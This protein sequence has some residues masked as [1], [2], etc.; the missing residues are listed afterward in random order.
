MDYTG[1]RYLPWIENAQAGY[2]HLHRYAFVLPFVR[3]KRVLDLATG[4]GYGAAMLAGE[5]AHVTGVDIAREAIA[6]ASSRYQR[7]NLTFVQG[8]M[9]DVPEI[10]GNEFDV[11]VCFESI[12]HVLDQAEVLSEAKRLLREGGLFFISTPNKLL[13]GDAA[14]RSWPWHEKELYFNEFQELVSGQFSHALFLGQM[15]LTG[16]A[17]WPLL[18]PREKSGFVAREVVISHSGREFM[19]SDPASKA[20]M[21][22]LAVASDQPLDALRREIEGP[23]YLVDASRRILTE[24]RAL[25]EKLE[26]DVAK[27]QGFINDK[28]NDLLQVVEELRQARDSLASVT[29]KKQAA[30]AAARDLQSELQDLEARLEETRR[31]RD[32]SFAKAGKL[33]DEIKHLNGSLNM[34]FQAREA[35][36]GETHR[37]ELQVETLNQSLAETREELTGFRAELADAEA[38]KA[39]LADQL[40]AM[41]SFLQHKEQ[42]I[43]IA[44]SFIEGVHASLG[45]RLLQRLRGLVD[46]LA[47][48]RTRRRWIYQ[49]ALTSFRFVARSVGLGTRHPEGAEQVEK[50]TGQGTAPRSVQPSDSASS[51]LS[52][53]AAVCTVASKNYLPYVRALAESVARHNPGLRFFVL[54]VDRLE[55][56]FDPRSEPYE[57]IFADQ[58]DNIPNKDHFFFKY[59]A[60]EL[61]TAIKPYLFQHLFRGYGLKKLAYFDPDVLLCHG[62]GGLW[63]LLETQ[64]IVLT[65]HIMAPYTD[66]AWPTEHEIN[67]AGIFNLGFIGLRQAP[68]TQAFLS[69]WADRLYDQCVMDHAAGLH[70]DQKWVNFAPTMFDGVFILR[71][72]AYNI[73]YWNLHSTGR[74][75]RY[76][77]SGL[78][79]DGRPV[80]FFHFS[81]F[82]PDDIESLSKHQ[83]R[84]RLSQF[85]NLKPLFKDYREIILR[86]GWRQAKGWQ[87]AYGR[88]EDGATIP[89]PARILYRE[90]GPRSLELGNPFHSVGS[91]GVGAWLNEPADGQKDAFPQ[92]TRLHMKIYAMRPD[93]QEAFPDPLGQDRRDFWGWLISSAQRDFGL[94]EVFLPGVERAGETGPPNGRSAEAMVRGARH[95]LRERLKPP[96]KNLSRGRPRLG[97]LLRDVDSRLFQREASVVPGKPV[98]PMFEALPFGVNVAGYIKGEFGVA[99]IARASITALEAAGIPR[100]LNMVQVGVHRHQ[101][102]T[103]TGFSDTNPYRVN[104]IHVNADQIPSFWDARGTEYARNRYNIGVWFWELSRFPDRWSSSFRQLDEIWVASAFCQ[105]SI[106]Q[107]SPVPVLRMPFPILSDATHAAADRARFSIPDGTFAFLFYFDYLSVFERKN[108]LA[109]IEAFK[110]AFGGDAHVMLVLKSINSEH[111]PEKVAAVR[112]AIGEL[113]V[114]VIDRHLDRESMNSLMASCDS[115]VSLHRS[116]GYGLGMVQ[117]M[118]MGK[119]VIATSYSG[120]MEFM[121]VNNSLLVR[122]TLVELDKDYGPYERGCV[123]AEP[124]IEH[125]VQLMRTAAGGGEAVERLCKRAAVDVR[126]RMDALAAGLTMRR[127]LGQVAGSE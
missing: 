68:S 79:I 81:G 27:L 75:L 120:N 58:L 83:N 7:P 114:K 9:Q 88:F 45:F 18:A 109:T 61:N 3:G 77:E 25:T 107:A 96:A 100:A 37:V 116:E 106:A 54:L 122:Y 33:E 94:E 65:P 101:D 41:E 105:Q 21:F 62:L 4:E 119:P 80:V 95:S 15:V 55:G 121:D 90:Y 67:Q 102:N 103:F 127:R 56:E 48:Y 97:R 12:E 57:I 6:H 10:A 117:A 22:F 126:T 40:A 36:E 125:A 20:A 112:D 64:A 44:A 35:A 32:A 76:T 66:Q 110:R 38:A 50:A 89:E 99:E 98:R 115:F 108:P 60:L 43:R 118:S 86:N 123:W 5:A 53:E 39:D 91:S 11:I 124:D 28:E 74:R 92:I 104:L 17:I 14:G 34:A 2:E 31:D 52:A 1:E 59:N 113:N 51:S 63:S 71:D 49:S 8:S 93:L 13:F 84:Y 70:V 85:P 19:L 73:A 72:P 42:D 29:D 82:D 46:R 30:D 111:S 16:S 78:L 47:P 69:W 23:S 26:G 24:Y 87:Y